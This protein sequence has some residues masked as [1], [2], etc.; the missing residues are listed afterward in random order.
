MVAQNT[1]TERVIIVHFT[2]KATLRLHGAHV[3][4]FLEN[5][6]KSIENGDYCFYS[7][8]DTEDKII[9]HIPQ[10][11]F[12]EETTIEVKEDEVLPF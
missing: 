1:K 4:N 9:I 10:V 3:P 8:E 12:I 5:Y 6:K 2:G 11:T 7:E